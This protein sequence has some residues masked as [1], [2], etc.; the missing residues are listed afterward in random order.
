MRSH[1][2]A[3]SSVSGLVGLELLGSLLNELPHPLLSPKIMLLDALQS[4]LGIIVPKIGLRRGIQSKKNNIPSMGICRLTYRIIFI[5]I[6]IAAQLAVQTFLDQISR[7]IGRH[8]KGHHAGNKKK[9][10]VLHSGGS[11]TRDKIGKSR[12]TAEIYVK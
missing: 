12:P 5:G 9:G 8:G 10:K 11:S 3:Q 4:G 6:T 2:F 1:L 7:V